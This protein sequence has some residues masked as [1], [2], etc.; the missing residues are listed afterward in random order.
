MDWRILVEGRIA[1]IC[2]PLDV[3][4]FFFVS[5]F[6]NFYIYR[7]LGSLR[8]SLLCILAELAREG[9]VALAVGVSDR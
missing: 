5:G 1:N 3:L 6:L 7:V 9:S 8:T 4:E 2:I